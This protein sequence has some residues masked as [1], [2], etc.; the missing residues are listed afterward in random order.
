MKEAI[1]IFVV[2]LLLLLIIS[3]F[4]GSIRYGGE[5]YT[6]AAAPAPGAPV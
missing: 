2:L 6:S 5:S 4:G 1:V 3:V